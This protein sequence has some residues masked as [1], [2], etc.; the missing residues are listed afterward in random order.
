MER[1]SRRPHV[2]DFKLSNMRVE[3]HPNTRGR[4]NITYP[5]PTRDFARADA[6]TRFELDALPG[7]TASNDATQRGIGRL[8]ARAH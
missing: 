7:V 5:G 3:Q 1:L 2:T 4:G 8:G 6:S